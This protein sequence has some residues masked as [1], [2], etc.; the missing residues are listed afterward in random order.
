M[1]IEQEISV[2]AAVELITTYA[3]RCSRSTLYRWLG[4]LKIEPVGGYISRDDLTL[5]ILWAKAIYRIRDV[6]KTA[7]TVAA[8][9]R[10]RT[11]SE[12]E[13]F[14]FNPANQFHQNTR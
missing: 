3:G 1:E 13:A 6:A 4:H 10:I 12:L 7:K 2:S 11:A 9:R 14:A 8:M 5:L